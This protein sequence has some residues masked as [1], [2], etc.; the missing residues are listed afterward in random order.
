VTNCR[1]PLTVGV[2]ECSSLFRVLRSPRHLIVVAKALP[3]FIRMMGHRV[4]FGF[5]RVFA[6]GGD[7]AQY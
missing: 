7:V 3:S 5:T 1:V 2:I 6:M 4:L